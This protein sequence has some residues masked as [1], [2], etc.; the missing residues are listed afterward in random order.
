MRIADLASSC[1]LRRSSA[2]SSAAA[3]LNDCAVL[4]AS[5]MLR[6]GWTNRNSLGVN[7][8]DDCGV[9]L[10]SCSMIG[11]YAVH[12]GYLVSSAA[13]KHRSAFS[14]IWLVRS[15]CPSAAGWYAAVRPKVIPSFEQRDCQ[16][17]E[18]NRA[19]RS[20][21]IRDGRPCVG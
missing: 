18:V 7:P 10:I 4:R 21:I 17:P 12:V 19:S 3:F 9:E 8:V 1:L 20:E 14:T 6:G 15:A 2:Q 5:G 16:N 11:R 13:I